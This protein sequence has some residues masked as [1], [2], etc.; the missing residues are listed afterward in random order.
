MAGYGGGRDYGYYGYTAHA[1]SSWSGLSAAFFSSIS[2]F[3]GIFLILSFLSLGIAA[4][5]FYLAEVAEEHTQLTRKIIG[6]SIKGI[7]AIYVLLF[8]VDGLP[9]FCVLSGIGAHVLYLQLLKTYPIVDPTSNIFLG[10]S[11]AGA[12][13]VI[14]WSR[15]FLQHPRC[16]YV[17]LGW[18]I[19]FMA[20]TVFF[21]PFLFLISLTTS[22]QSLP[23]VSSSSDSQAS[24][25]GFL[26]KKRTTA[27]SSLFR[28]LTDRRD[29]V[30]PT[31]LPR[32][33][34]A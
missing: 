16:A 8:V 30:L 34:Q 24:S 20:V 7:L 26:G 18:A 15:F 31:A 25:S 9:F 32:P 2:A 29:Q 19:G 17:T 13:S 4:G 14:M 5:L 6:I 12:L 23:H 1:T 27:V 22:S 33:R 28:F 10:S 11:G 3:T 21:V